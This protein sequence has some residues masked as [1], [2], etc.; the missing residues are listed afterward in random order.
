MGAAVRPAPRLRVAAQP[1][2]ATI[3]GA[4][5]VALFAGLTAV[6]VTAVIL[7][8]QVYK[9][10][11]AQYADAAWDNSTS[12]GAA[13]LYAFALAPVFAV[14]DGD[15]AVR[16]AR[17]LNALLFAA[18]ALPVAAIARRAGA[19]PWAA[20]AAGVLAVAVPWLTLST[21][22]FSESLAYLLFACLVLAMLRA[23][24]AEGRS[25]GR[26]AV[27]LALLGAVVLTRLQFVVVAVAWVAYVVV[28][29]WRAGRRPWTR[30]P[31]TIACTVLALLAAAAR[32][33]TLA[34][35]Y[36]G[37]RDRDAVPGDFGLALL[38]E[39]EMLA[40]GVGVVPALLWAVWLR[41][42]LGRRLGEQARRVALVSTVMLAAL[43]A[44]T[45]WAQGGWLDAR[46]EERYFLY[47]VPFLWVAAA[48]ALSWRELSARSIA[49]AGVGLAVVLFV[50][51]NPVG[52]TGEQLFLGPVSALLAHG[53]PRIQN[54]LGDAV[55][56]RDLVTGKD[57]LGGC[58]L[59]LTLLAA[60]AWRSGRRW[61][62]LVPAALVQLALVGF[63]FAGMHGK[64]PD[65]GGATFERSFAGLGWVDRAT[66]GGA[67]VS[68][69]DNGSAKREL[70][71]RETIFYNDEVLSFLRVEEAMIPPPAYPAF[72]LPTNVARV[73]PD[74][75]LSAPPPHPLAVTTA[76]SPLWQ[77]EAETV[78]TSPDGELRLVRPA[79]PTRALWLAAGLE[80]DGHVGREVEV[81]AA[82]GHRYEIDVAAP[83]P[84]A[85]A[86]V[87]VTLGERSRVFSSLQRDE[88]TLRFDL[89]DA[90]RP[91]TGRME[92]VAA[93]PL[94][95]DRFSAGQLRA[96]RVTPCA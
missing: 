88:D 96:V 25:L 50:V 75:V 78:A 34:G 5:L 35:P 1:R 81:R 33:Q 84:D 59:L 12:R 55:G 89:C 74:L 10:A 85:D 47:A 69:L 95:G 4:L 71:Q 52:A 86:K 57:L 66:P 43:A 7:D 93:V 79:T 16:V 15:V 82:P 22:I 60:L 20:A 21:I 77:L 58:A 70:Q 30:F 27:V 31:L 90:T 8:E 51:P 36:Y 14:F 73:G 11:A 65:V 40:V 37:L 94:G 62:A 87:R 44:G 56:I 61:L 13:R 92:Q 67:D 38:W 2:V 19:T 45:L 9:F 64:L 23:V 17:A 48:A 68:M 41:G 54:W 80:L 83:V 26:E 32:P 91:V 3:V 39:V 63:A 18:T 53:L 72:T 6:E 42:A 46:S 49:L 76:D 28:S 24:E 29:E